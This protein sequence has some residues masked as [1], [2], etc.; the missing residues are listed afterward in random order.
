[1]PTPSTGEQKQKQRTFDVLP[2][3]DKL[4]SY[5]HLGNI[6]TTECETLCKGCHAE[7]HGKVTPQ[8]GWE[9]IGSDDLGG[10]NGNCELCGTEL[11]YIFLIDHE[12]WTAIAVGTDCCDKLTA[13]NEASSFLDGYVKTNDRRKKFVSSTRWRQLNSSELTVSQKGIA[14]CISLSNGKYRISMDGVTG[15]M[16]YESLIDA[17]IEAFNSIE[18]GKASKYLESRKQSLLRSP[19]RS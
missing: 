8:S 2:K 15:R 1:L 18:S 3:P 16:E 17:K 11:R 6:I 19:P 12:N 14:V 5:R 7:E 9:L 10:L 13:T 4:I